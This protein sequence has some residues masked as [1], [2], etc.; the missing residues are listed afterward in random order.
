MGV[1]WRVVAAGQLPGTGLMG[2]LNTLRDQQICAA[3]K[4]SSQHPGDPVLVEMLSGGM[5]TSSGQNVT[6]DTALR[7]AA[8]Y[9]AVRRVSAGGGQEIFLPGEIFHLRGL[10]VNGGLSGLNPIE[11]H[12]ETV[13]LGL[14]MQEYGA[15]F[16]AN[17]ATPSGI[18]KHPSH[19]KD[20]GKRNEFRRSFIE[21]TTGIDRHAPVVLEDNIEFTALGIHPKTTNNI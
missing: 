19:F 1:V 12:R 13:G 4:S 5:R 17:A 18:L 10:S 7:L 16:Y 9:A 14:A 20:A 2:I 8:V 11:Y 21:Q 3:T 6:P 15:K